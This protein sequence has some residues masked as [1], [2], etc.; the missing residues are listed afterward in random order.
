MADGKGV[1]GAE[2]FDSSNAEGLRG[3]DD[4]GGTRVV[5]FGGGGG[6]GGGRTG[7]V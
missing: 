6:G 7:R 1:G 3:V 5:L 4:D 2:K